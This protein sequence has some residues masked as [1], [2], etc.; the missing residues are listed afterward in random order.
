[1]HEL[2][3]LEREDLSAHEP[4]DREP[5]D[6]TER[7]EDAEETARGLVELSDEGEERSL[8][9]VQYRAQV[10]DNDDD[11][12][13]AWEGEEHV[14]GAHHERVDP[15]AEV[16]RGEPERNTDHQHDEHVDERHRERDPAPVEEPAE[17]IAAELVGPEE[18]RCARTE[19][20]ALEVLPVER[21]RR[22]GA[23]E[24]CD[25]DQQDDKDEA[26]NRRAV[27]RP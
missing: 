24:Q 6:E 7:D 12:E 3:L 17:L 14:D 1:F 10:R 21:V 2:L 27:P 11:E 23:G 18:M 26:H 19:I 9:L 20:G 25:D 15:A 5:R 8:W 16:A 4:R 13:Q 22:E